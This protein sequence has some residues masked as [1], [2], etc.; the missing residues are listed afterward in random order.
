MIFKMTNAKE[1]LYILGVFLAGYFASITFP[2]Y[3]AY[4]AYAEI[5]PLSLINFYTEPAI[6]FIFYCSKTLGLDGAK[7]LYGSAAVS[8]YLAHRVGIQNYN[9]KK[10]G[11]FT[12]FIFFSL[13]FY[14][15][16]RTPREALAWF[17]IFY[18]ANTSNLWAKTLATFTA[19]I[20]HN[21]SAL[22]ILPVI[23]VGFQNGIFL[24]VFI[25]ALTATIYLF[26]LN[27][28]DWSYVKNAYERFSNR[29][30]VT[31]RVRV[32]ILIVSLTLA[33]MIVT[34][35]GRVSAQILALAVMAILS[36]LAYFDGNAV[37]ARFSYLVSV[38]LTFAI[39]RKSY[40]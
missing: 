20:C 36:M 24:V 10:L 34:W 6:I 11:L 35:R 23:L 1:G 27:G 21:A 26:S 25:S 37:I 31:G 2:D 39:L 14:L 15:V 38:L 28:V 16:L 8:I 22:L 12:F 32:G 18:A 17:P 40:I 9:N 29:G 13:S 3:V 33:L 5:D 19:I 30:T 4:E 7:I